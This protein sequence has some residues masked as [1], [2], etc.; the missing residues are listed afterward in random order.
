MHPE[1]AGFSG[2]II[3]IQDASDSLTHSQSYSIPNDIPTDE[4][5]EC[6]VHIWSIIYFSLY[7]LIYSAGIGVFSI[8]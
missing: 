5:V 7:D 8:H 6:L 3:F 4:S 1:F 2:L